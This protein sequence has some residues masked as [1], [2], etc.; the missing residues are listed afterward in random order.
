[1]TSRVT[2]AL[3]AALVLTS[4]TVPDTSASKSTG[5]TQL[6]RAVT[7]G[8]GT[9]I[10]GLAV[11]DPDSHERQGFDVDL[12]RWLGNNT[13]PKFTPVEVD[14]LIANRVNE[15]ALGRVQLVVHTFS[16]TDERRGK[17]GFAGPYLISQQ[18]VLVREGDDRIRTIDDLAGKTVCSQ[19][20]STSYNQLTSGSLKGRVTTT[21][22]DGTRQC[23][24]RLL[25]GDV[26]AA[27]TDQII[28]RGFA[29][30]TPGLKVLDLTFGAQERYGVGL[31][32]GD[33]ALCEQITDGIRSFITDGAW[34]QFFRT[35][36]GEDLDLASHKPDPYRLDPCP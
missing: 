22:E 8:V 36:F 10:P 31:P 14:V 26:D 21:S 20:G 6:V 15:I 1:M 11:L 2:A 17:I 30:Q 23:I 3:A 19:A 7:V 13:E 5:H 16:I 25:R 4:C 27:S 9:D 28:L 34:D 32:K 33:R 24:D 12:Y 29:R 18:G 35:N